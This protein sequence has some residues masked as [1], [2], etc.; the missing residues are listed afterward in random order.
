MIRC[1]RIAIDIFKRTTLFAF[2]YNTYL[3]LTAQGPSLFL[4]KMQTLNTLQ[5]I[6]MGILK[7]CKRSQ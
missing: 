7:L 4:Y 1:T 2:I 5:P 3:F 6:Q